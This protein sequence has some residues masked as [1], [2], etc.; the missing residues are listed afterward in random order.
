VQWRAFLKKN[1]LDAMDLQEVVRYVR[2]RVL[3]YGFADA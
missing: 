1:K 2:G 3:Q